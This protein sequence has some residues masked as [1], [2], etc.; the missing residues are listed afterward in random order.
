MSIY[1]PN[2]GSRTLFR[3]AK[4][5]MLYWSMDD[6]DWHVIT[7]VKHSRNEHLDVDTYRI[8]C[9]GTLRTVTAAGGPLATLEP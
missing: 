3:D 9:R 4:P 5:G 6:G 2:G 7:S 8:V 1:Y